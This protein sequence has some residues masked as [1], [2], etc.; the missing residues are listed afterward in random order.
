MAEGAQFIGIDVGTGSARAAIF[1][2][3]GRMLA[4]AARDIQLWRPETLTE[5]DL[6][7]MCRAQLAGYKQPKAIRFIAIEEFPRSASG[8]IQR[9]LLEERLAK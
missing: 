5:A 4:H 6:H 9:H 7:E 8:K 1:D 2:H 3:A